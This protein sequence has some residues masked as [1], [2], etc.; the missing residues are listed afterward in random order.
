MKKKKRTYVKKTD[1]SLYEGSPFQFEIQ[2]HIFRMALDRMSEMAKN[3]EDTILGC[4]E[5]KDP[6]MI[7]KRKY[8]RRKVKAK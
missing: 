6:E 2:L 3:L 7:V 1:N 8:R 4:A 5:M